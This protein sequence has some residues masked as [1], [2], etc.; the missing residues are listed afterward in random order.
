MNRRLTFLTRGRIDTEIEL[1]TGNRLIG[2]LQQALPTG[3]DGLWIDLTDPDSPVL[4][5]IGPGRSEL[6]GLQ[7]G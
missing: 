2:L 6:L 1:P 4:N 3:A 5:R 7:G